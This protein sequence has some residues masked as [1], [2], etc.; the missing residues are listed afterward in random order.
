MSPVSKAQQKAIA[1]YEDK[2]YD[3]FLVRVPK[4]E[5]EVIHAHAEA[6]GES[7]NAFVGRAIKETIERDT[8]NR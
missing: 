2:V 1:K 3:K 7:L 8:V 5:K 4:G 6:R